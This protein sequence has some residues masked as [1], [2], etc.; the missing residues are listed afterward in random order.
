M[1]SMKC[2]DFDAHTEQAKLPF[3]LPLPVSRYN[4]SIAK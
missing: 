4:G 3:L 1:L 2:F